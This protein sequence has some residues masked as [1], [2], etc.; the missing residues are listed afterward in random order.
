MFLGLGKW[1]D[2]FRSVANHQTSCCT[3]I[4]WSRTKAQRFLNS[5]KTFQYHFKLKNFRIPEFSELQLK[6]KLAKI[7]EMFCNVKFLEI[8]NFHKIKNQN[9]ILNFFFYFFF[10]ISQFII[11]LFR[12][13]C[14]ETK[15]ELSLWSYT[16][17]TYKSAS[18]Q[19]FTE[20]ME[21]V[22]DCGMIEFE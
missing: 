11:W 5:H 12:F 4:C 10:L 15:V 22:Q 20:D 3:L 19:N 8:L 7:H 17:Q 9:P 18:I 14:V 21:D 16:W 1:K 6:E 13:T 2:L